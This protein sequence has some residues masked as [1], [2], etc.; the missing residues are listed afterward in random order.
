MNC[1]KN[2]LKSLLS[3][4]LSC[5]SLSTIQEESNKPKQK[6]HTCLNNLQHS[7][8][9]QSH[10]KEEQIC[11]KI[12]AAF[13]AMKRKKKKKEELLTEKIDSIIL[14]D[15]NIQWEHIAACKNWL[16]FIIWKP[17]Q[18]SN[19][20]QK[21]KKEL[22]AILL[23]GKNTKKNSLLEKTWFHYMIKMKIRKYSC[24]NNLGSIMLNDINTKRK[25]M[26]VCHSIK[27]QKHTK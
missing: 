24:L 20:C 12:F 1:S 4:T 23:N 6:E 19:K 14:N 22:P 21:H 26:F 8:E 3:F 16:H 13:L 7:P 17:Y 5:L 15:K 11:F 9:W 25:N 27:W 18:H 2:H 10:R